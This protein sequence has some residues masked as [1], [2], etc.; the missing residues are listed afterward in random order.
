MTTR[1]ANLKMNILFIGDVVGN[2]GRR[3]V[4]QY[5]KE[6]DKT[7][8]TT[9]DFIVVNAENAAGGKGLTFDIVDQFLAAGVTAIT[10]GN[11][12]WAQKEIFDFVDTT[13]QLIRPANY[14][15][16]VPG[17]GFTVVDS[18]DGKT[19]LGVINLAGQIFMDRY[20]NPFHELDS[21]LTEVREET[22]FVLLDFHAEAT[23]EKI[24][25]GW[26]ADGR[27]SAV[28]GTHTHVQTADERVLPQ[29]TAYISD[30]GMTGPHDSVIGSRKE[31]VLD[32]F[33]TLMPTRFGIANNNIRLNAVHIELNAETGFA[34]SIERIQ[35]KI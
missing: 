27:V 5:L 23:S 13:P 2:P 15:A 35:Y 4:T 18:A 1:N 12:V 30:V 3:A 8:E 9:Y 11:H 32:S 34:E 26:H 20:S 21:I 33:L 14:P 17:R 22:P 24:A 25:M 10:T 16:D 6:I 31:Q 29:G 7:P 19:R 28:I